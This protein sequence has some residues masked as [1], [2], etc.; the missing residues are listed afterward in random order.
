MIKKLSTFEALRKIIIEEM[1]LNEQSVIIYNQK[2]NIPT[3]QGLWVFVEFKYSRMISAR[4]TPAGNGPTGALVERQDLNMQEHYSIGIMSRDTAALERKEEVVMALNSVYSQQVQEENSFKIFR[5]T[6]IQDVS[7]L[8]GTAILYRFD[9]DIV[10]HAWYA[11]TKEPDYFDAFE[12]EVK[13]EKE[14]V[15][16][17]QPTTAVFPPS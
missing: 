5:Q 9:V 16:F 17:E 1:D 12:V 8:E 4:S 14:S 11:G 7:E 15:T 13:T 10:V 6:P 2:A 3:T